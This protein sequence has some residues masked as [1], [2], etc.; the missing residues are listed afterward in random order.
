MRPD[1]VSRVGFARLLRARSERGLVFIYVA[2]LGIVLIGAV[3]LALDTAMVASA[4]QQL[5]YAADAAA[6]AAVQRVKADA[7]LQPKPDYTATR[8]VAMDI[9]HSN[10]AGGALVQLDANES[11]SPDGDIVVGFWNPDDQSFKPDVENPN[12]VRVQARRSNASIGGPLELV[13]GPLFGALTS[14][15]EVSA[16]ATYGLKARPVVL[17]LDPT[18]A[19]ALQL[20]GATMLDAP[21]GMV[22]VNS[23]DA[24]AI[25]LSGT[26]LLRAMKVSTP[27]GICAAPGLI[28]GYL[29]MGDPPFADPF[30]DQLPSDAAWDGYKVR[31]PLPMGLHGAIT[32]PGSFAPGYYPGGISLTGQ[33]AATLLPGVYL[34][35]GAGLTLR[36]SATLTGSQVVL[37]IDRGAQVDVRGSANLILSAPAPKPGTFFGIALF[38]HRG[39]AGLAAAFGGTGE[40]RIQ[41]SVYVPSGLFRMAGGPNQSIESLIAWRVDSV[42]NASLRANGPSHA[43]SH[44]AAYLV[45]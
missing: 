14:E 35:G 21:T 18:G 10:K 31:L 36:G 29:Q 4:R 43:Q 26:P 1:S 6:L 13:F 44:T 28:D 16:I 25:K 19:G 7:A 9:A 33:T 17:V 15:V 12:A 20:D 8:Q 11:N 2:L 40:V 45:E 24:C 34:L 38:S 32:A 41:G 30:A 42:G 22:Q 37:L 5:Q 23:N 3:G 27:G 39:N